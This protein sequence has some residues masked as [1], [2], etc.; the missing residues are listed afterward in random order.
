MTVLRGML[1][2]A[3]AASLLGAAYF[4][5]DSWRFAA[6]AAEATGV[7]ADA[8]AEAHEVS[9]PHSGLGYSYPGFSTS[10]IV[11]TVRLTIEFVDART[12]AKFRFVSGFGRSAPYSVGDRVPVL[13][14]PDDPARARLAASLWGDGLFCAAV[15]LLASFFLGTSNPPWDARTRAGSALF[16]AVAIAFWTLRLAGFVG[17][18]SL[19]VLPL[20]LFY[21]AFAVGG[22]VLLG[23]F[24]PSDETPEPL[25]RRARRAAKK[26]R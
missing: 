26:A 5:A 7:V 1:F 9:R 18:A 21:A 14:D 17:P 3:V 15:C 11:T 2:F 10:R 19:G 6:S 13:Y 16:A 8:R 23:Y 4:F 20:A 24:A 25:T 12:Q 22:F